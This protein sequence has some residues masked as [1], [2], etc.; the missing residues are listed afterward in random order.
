MDP[1]GVLEVSPV[2]PGGGL[3]AFHHKSKHRSCTTGMNP[4]SGVNVEYAVA[5]PFAATR[6]GI[7]DWG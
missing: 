2:P 4:Y 6:L 5:L 7:D 1:D 3:S